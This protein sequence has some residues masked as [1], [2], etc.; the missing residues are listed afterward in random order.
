MNC[1]CISE[2]AGKM[3]GLQYKGKNVLG[4]KLISRG[5]VMVDGQLDIVTCSVMELDVDGFKKPQKV[6]LY[7]SFCPFCGTEIKKGKSESNVEDPN[8]TEDAPAN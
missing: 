6:D 5:M 8:P 1:N 4:G 7:H 2:L 3:S